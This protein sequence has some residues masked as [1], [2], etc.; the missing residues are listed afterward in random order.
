M[1]RLQKP[2][3]LSVLFCA[4]LILL[5]AL[6]S[7]CATS[8]ETENAG[9]SPLPVR[10]C[11]NTFSLTGRVS[12]QYTQSLP[13][14]EESLHGKFAWAQN[15]GHARIDLASPFGQ[16][17]AVMTL[18]PEEAVLAASGEQPVAAANAD[19]LFL[20]QMGWPLPVSG[21]AHWLQGCAV[22]PGGTLFQA[23]PAHPEITTQKGW[24]IRYLDWT[25]LPENSLAPRRI[26]L[27]YDPPPDAPVSQ[28]RIRLVIDEWLPNP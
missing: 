13:D 25:A 6:F 14:R 11:G 19:Q 21:L 23:S 12:V 2:S 5:C 9:E 15:G 24:R 16:T 28:I 22:Q 26:N 17:L 1:A 27:A 7:G 10:K 4:A 18:S 3:P 20:Q 8:P